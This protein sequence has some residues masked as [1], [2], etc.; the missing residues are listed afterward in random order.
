MLLTTNFFKIL[1][2]NA[3]LFML[4]QSRSLNERLVLYFIC[5]T[6][7]IDLL[8]MLSNFI[9]FICPSPEIYSHSK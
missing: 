2:L 4:I 1:L 6:A 8:S 3:Y 9:A 7:E 5:L